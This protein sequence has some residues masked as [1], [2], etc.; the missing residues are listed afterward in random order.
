MN[1]QKN[2]VYFLIY[3]SQ[4]YTAIGLKWFD[5]HIR[6]CYN[7]NQKKVR[8]LMKWI[9]IHFEWFERRLQVVSIDST[10][11]NTVCKYVSYFFSILIE[12]F[13]IIIVAT[14]HSLTAHYLTRSLFPPLFFIRFSH[15]CGLILVFSCSSSNMNEF[16]MNMT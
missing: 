5:G 3:N 4:V 6:W 11:N 16:G 15:S 2:C 12:L 1:F 7:G 10:K 14:I 9:L 13:S 8:N